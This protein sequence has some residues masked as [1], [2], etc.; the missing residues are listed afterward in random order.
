MIYGDSSGSSSSDPN[1]ARSPCTRSPCTRSPGDDQGDARGGLRPD[2]QR[3]RPAR[4]RGLGQGLRETGER[5]SDAD[6][7]QSPFALLLP[8]ATQL[9]RS[10]ALPGM[11]TLTAYAALCRHPLDMHDLGT[12]KE[13]TMVPAS[14]L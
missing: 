5:R 11:K 1:P 7:A 10:H 4:P 14:T 13:K 3:L 9:T 2:C 8:G 12:V 6:V